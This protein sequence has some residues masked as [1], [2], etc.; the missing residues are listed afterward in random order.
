[1]SSV[2]ERDITHIRSLHNAELGSQRR[3]SSKS[4]EYV[5]DRLTSRSKNRFHAVNCATSMMNHTCEQGSGVVRRH[6]WYNNGEDKPHVSSH[7]CTYNQGI[8]A[9]RGKEKFF[10]WPKQ[11]MTAQAWHAWKDMEN[12]ESAVNIIMLDMLATDKRDPH[13]PVETQHVGGNI[14]HEQTPSSHVRSE[15]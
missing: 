7:V 8:M 11:I 2:V 15:W 13:E 10:T 5:T 14:H 9:K 12:G 3:V 1:M 6:K 4:V